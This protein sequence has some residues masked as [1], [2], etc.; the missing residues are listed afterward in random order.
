MG[1]QQRGIRAEYMGSAQ[2]DRTVN[3]RAENGEFDILYMTPE[4]ACAVSQRSVT[5]VIFFYI[6]LFLTPFFLIKIIIVILSA[7]FVYVSVFSDLTSFD[8]FCIW[9]C[10]FW[11]ALLRRGVSLLAVDE[12]HCVS[13]W[14]HDFRY[15]ILEFDLF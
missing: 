2:R 14:G 12:A 8:D 10:S 6:D 1:L 11:T 13:E 7:T 5:S 9:L 4:K 3:N 15:S